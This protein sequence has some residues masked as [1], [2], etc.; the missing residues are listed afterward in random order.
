MGGAIVVAVILI[1]VALVLLNSTGSGG[2]SGDSSS[3]GGGAVSSG[4]TASP[5]PKLQQLAAAIAQAEGFGIEGA[6][7]TLANNPGDLVLG[8]KGYGTMGAA[9]IT[10][11]ASAQDGWNALY[12]E[13]NL[14]FSGTSH[15]YTTAMTFAQVA[16]HWTQT[17]VGSWAHNVA[18]YVGASVNDSLAAWFERF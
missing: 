14:I 2:G 11:F 6:I 17:E 12:H 8:D 13:L 18:T 9:G 3:G 16:A 7:P 15:V 4:G 5:N 10:V 1:G